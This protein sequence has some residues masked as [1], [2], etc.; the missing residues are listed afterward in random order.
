V[1]KIFLN[2][3]VYQEVSLD[4]FPEREVQS[5]LASRAKLIFPGYHYAHFNALITC[6]EESAKPDF[7]LIE[8]NYR[9]WHVGE[10]EMIRHDLINHVLRQIRVFVGGEYG[11]KHVK[12]VVNRFPELDAKRIQLLIENEPPGVL[13]IADRMDTQWQTAIHNEGAKMGIFEIFRRGTSSDLL[14]RVNGDSPEVPDILSICEPDLSMP[15]LLRVKSPASI[16]AKDKQKLDIEFQ[17]RL[18]EWKYM[19]AEDKAWLNPIGYPLT[20]MEYIYSLYVGNDGILKLEG[21][22]NATHSRT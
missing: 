21:K 3:E 9:K 1:A 6:Q 17:G 11:P 14:F 19:L 8:N 7:I 22:P 20:K 12:A 4:L 5:A 18:T 10:V 13:V 16:P 15:R 2:E